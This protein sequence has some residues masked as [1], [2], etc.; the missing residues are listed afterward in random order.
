MATETRKP[1]LAHNSVCVQHLKDTSR[2]SLFQMEQAMF[3]MSNRD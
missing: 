2:N 3:P 1:G